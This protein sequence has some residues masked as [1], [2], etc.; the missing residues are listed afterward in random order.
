MIQLWTAAR[1]GP[2]DVHMNRSVMDEASRRIRSQI[3]ISTNKAGSGHPTSS[4][5]AA[6]LITVLAGKYLRWDLE[7]PDSTAHDRL[8]FSKGHA[9]PL[10]YAVLAEVGAIPGKDLS[11]LRTYGSTL[12]G[13]PVPKV[14]FV[15]VATG[16]LGQG[17]SVGIGMA[18][19]TRLLYPP[20]VAEEPSQLPRIYVL[21][22]D[23]EL[24]EGQVW[25]AATL[26][27]HRQLWNLTL[28]VDMNC[29]GQ[30][31]PTIHGYNPNVLRRKF[32]AFGWGVIC[33]NGHTYAEIDAAYEKALCYRSGPTAIIAETIKG[34][35]VSFLENVPGKHGVP[36]TDAELKRALKELGPISRTIRL[37][38][39]K[40]GVKA[41]RSPASAGT[42]APK[43]PQGVAYKPEDSIPTR[44]AF[45]QAIKLMGSDPLMVVI[46]GD[47]QNSTCTEFFAERYPDR[48]I[49]GFIA[50]QNMVSMAAGLAAYGFRP[51]VSTFAAFLTRA[52][53]QIRM[54]ALSGTTIKINGSHGGVSIGQDGPSQMGL[55]DITMMRAVPGSIVVCPSDAVSTYQLI[56]A[57]TNNPGISYVRT[58]RPATP[59][60]YPTNEE[61]PIGGSKVHTMKSQNPN[62]KIQIPK[63]HQNSP[64]MQRAISY[65][66]KT[67][68]VIVG[69]GITVIEA[70]K[71]QTVLVGN[72]HDAVVI[73]CYSIKPIDAKTLNHQTAAC[74]LL[75]VVED[76]YPEGGLGEAVLSALLHKP[77]HYRHLAVRKVPTSGTP[78]ELMHNQGIDA[79]AIVTAVKE[80]G[81]LHDGQGASTESAT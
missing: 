39:R 10:L 23:G 14:P 35:G 60:I 28:I 9:S 69:T 54:A 32:E 75:V 66:S 5:S 17:V 40:P 61:F 50:E 43:S 18:L 64:P 65:Q 1:P 46:D 36:L 44:K 25:E 26:A 4:L 58:Q 7:N 45:G 16:S 70:L 11:T 72:G 6:D 37:T 29:L 77:P 47:V 67:R 41:V 3:L 49:Q 34:K 20:T 27:A 71:A 13:H 80:S 73:D 53:D 8:I 63:K 59:V 33:V 24:M 15:D 48:F 74:D 68:V 55:D 42:T 51:W 21:A 79:E 76:H 57:L 62:S 12:E 2:Y 78:G 31:G 81:L 52:H 22:G 56:S 19:A 38:V 30:S